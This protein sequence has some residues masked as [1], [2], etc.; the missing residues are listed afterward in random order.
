MSFDISSQSLTFH[1]FYSICVRIYN[2]VGES[3]FVM[4]AQMDLTV[5]VK[6]I[7]SVS[8]CVNNNN[9]LQARHKQLPEVH[10][11]PILIR[12]K[13]PHRWECC[14]LG[15]SEW[16]A[17]N[18]NKTYTHTKWFIQLCENVNLHMIMQKLC[19]LNDIRYMAATKQRP[20]S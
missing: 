10:P 11:R 7:L 1:I 18:A 16:I 19:R 14:L 4:C 9:N 6:G 5:T 3:I 12:L 2:V 8:N 17:N 20:Q 13:R 15:S